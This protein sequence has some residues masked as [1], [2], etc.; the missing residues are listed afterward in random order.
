MREVRK[1]QRKFYQIMKWL[2]ILSVC[3]IFVYI[4]VQPYIKEFNST[5]SLA[6]NY[7]C[8]I[9]VIVNLIVIFV[10]YSKY[11]KIEMF[12]KDIENEIDDAGY[13]ISAREMGDINKIS[14]E[15]LNSFRQSNYKI[16]QNIEI[17]DF[18]FDI[19]AIKGK[20][21]IYVANVESLDKNDVLA[22]LD[23]MIYD[24]T[25]NLYRRKGNAILCFVTDK[26]NDDAISVSK[27]ITPLG[28]KGQMRVALSMYECD[29]NNVYFQGNEENKAK[30]IIAN[31]IMNCELP[32]KDEFI[33]NDKLPFQY[34]LEEKVK[35]FTLKDYNSGSFYIH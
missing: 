14:G 31:Y 1:K 2:I 26:A 33:H 23:E 29:S 10:Y 28:R 3:F 13:Y 35:N 12:L 18:S 5:L 17:K 16:S 9:L 22:Y 30:T 19:R 34:E 20:N 6:V 15:I 7:F 11:G 27:M 4:G 8:D 21:Y 25:S 32:L 24:V